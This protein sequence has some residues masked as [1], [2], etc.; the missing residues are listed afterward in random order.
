VRLLGDINGDGT[1]DIIA[2]GDVGVATAL[3]IKGSMPG[4]VNFGTGP[5]VPD[6]GYDRGWRNDKH[7]RLLG[8]INNDGTVD[9]VA[10]GDAGVWTARASNDG[11]T[12]VQFASEFFGSHKY[13]AQKPE[14]VHGQQMSP[15]RR[16]IFHYVMGY[17]T[18]GGGCVVDII[19]CGFNMFDDG[20]SAHEFAH[21]IG[22]RHDGPAIPDNK[23]QAN[24]KPNYPSLINYAFLYTGYRQF[25]DGRRRDFPD[26]NNH[27]LIETNAVDPSNQ[28]LLNALENS[29]LYKVDRATGSVDWN[30]DGQFSAP[31][32]PV[33]A[34]ANYRPGEQCE[35]TKEEM[36]EAG[37]NS[38][39]SPAIV[40]FANTIWIFGI[41]L[42][43]KLA[44]THAAPAWN[45]AANNID[46]CP[47][48]HFT[49]VETHNVGA[50][51]A[52]DAKTLTINGKETVVLIGI[53][54]NGS[55]FEMT[56]AMEG[57]VPMLSAPAVLTGSLAKG[58]PSLASNFAKSTL[59]LAYQDR[60]DKVILRFR[61]AQG[62]SEEIQ[63]QVNGRPIAMSARSSPALVYAPLPV[64]HT[65]GEHL[66]G[67]FADP[68]N[69]L[70][71]Y[72]PQLPGHT[73]WGP[74]A[75]PYEGMGGVIGR[76]VMAWTGGSGVRVAMGESA[77]AEASSTTY[78]RLY[79]LFIRE[80]APAAGSP[81]PRN[82]MIMAMSYVD[83]Q[84]GQLRIGLV[85][86][87][88]NEWAYAYS[89]SLLTPSDG[90][91][92]RAAFTSAVED[93]HT[94]LPEKRI[95][96]RPHADGIVDRVYQNRDDWKALAFYTCKVLVAH[97]AVSPVS[98][99][100]AW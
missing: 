91:A 56:L 96:F 73:N 4:E 6:F 92:L 2:F 62:W 60:D 74:I 89:L 99:A 18:G 48:A 22:L 81:H 23:D 79:V 44:V 69:N 66:L 41:D 98:C 65:P 46:A 9:I 84:T 3:G 90:G 45:C 17:T 12:Q 34:Y 20:N 93:R 39:R 13:I 36:R 1:A 53:R 51:D 43:G 95:F 54:P 100:D 16:G 70:Q 59:A 83:R 49:P 52:L 31:G 47:L 21:T 28:P 67:A 7:V 11:F 37:I 68:Q 78:A 71:L 30:R 57:A 97:Q 29:F 35:F 75:I 5:S 77:P 27:A 63:P 32:A 15:G 72:M 55:V 80:G 87:Y 61:S 42:D 10:F 64:G 8:D 86:Y 50:I 33:R 40:R 85:S 88:D 58:E 94:K 26:L 24:C 14:V 19:A 38:V 76:P 82:P 25:S